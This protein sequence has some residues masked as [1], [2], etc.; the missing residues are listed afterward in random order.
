MFDQAAL[1]IG[2][3]LRHSASGGTFDLR[4][5]NRLDRIKNQQTGVLSLD[6]PEDCAK[7][8]VGRQEKVW[9]DGLDSLSPQADLGRRFLA[10][11]VQDPGAGASA[12]GGYIKQQGR[13]THPRFAGHQHH[14][15]RHQAPAENAI[16]FAHSGCPGSNQGDLYLIDRAGRHARLGR[17]GS[18]SSRSRCLHHSAPLLT[19]GAATDPLRRCPAAIGALPAG[20]RSSSR[21]RGGCRCHVFDATSHP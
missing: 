4:R 20:A 7:V 1:I 14:G 11:D 6:V 9:V 12:L 18:A 5:G 2:G 21:S 10:G 15:A 3:T 17:C 8:S 16:E 19:L 13:L